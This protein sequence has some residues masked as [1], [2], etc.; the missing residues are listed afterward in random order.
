M[1]F[2]Q[3]Q[4]HKQLQATTHTIKAGDWLK[5]FNNPK[6]FKVY[7]YGI[8]KIILAVYKPPYINLPNLP[9]LDK[10]MVKPVST[11]VSDI[12]HVPRAILVGP[13]GK[14]KSQK[15]KSR[16]YKS[17]KY[18]TRKHK[19]QKQKNRKKHKS[20]KHKSRKHK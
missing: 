7:V 1:A 15:Y 6:T 16:K 14:H 2:L 5:H 18:K 13:G 12:L 9:S 4:L 10:Q 8:E 19:S 3:H 17:Q 20:R 11:S